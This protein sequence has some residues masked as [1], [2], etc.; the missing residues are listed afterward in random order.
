MIMMA[1][2]EKVARPYIHEEPAKERKNRTDKGFGY[3][4]E[5]CRE[6]AQ[7][8]SESVNEKPLDSLTPVTPVTENHRNGIDTVRE[9][10]NE[11]SSC[12]DYANSARNLKR[13]TDSDAIEETVYGKTSCAKRAPMFRMLV[14]LFMALHKKTSIEKHIDNK[15]ETNNEHDVTCARKRFTESYRFWYEI[16]KSDSN[17][18]SR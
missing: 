3:R 4:E 13:D 5:K 10:M 8:R 16:K 1:F 14:T 9:V 17:E 11:H 12:D 2:R 7:N 6:N 15:T 18:S